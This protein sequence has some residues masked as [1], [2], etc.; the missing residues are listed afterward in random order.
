MQIMLNVAIAIYIAVLVVLYFWRLI[1][2]QQMTNHAK[3]PDERLTGIRQ[4]TSLTDPS[5]YTEAGQ[6]YRLRT[7][8]V[9]RAMMMWGMGIPVLL[10]IVSR[11]VDSR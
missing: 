5:Q 2:W 9:G 7:M 1:L 4:A 3:S 10:W 6:A 8:K 11:F